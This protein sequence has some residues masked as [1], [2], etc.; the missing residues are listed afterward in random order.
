MQKSKTNQKLGNLHH[1]FSQMRL[2]ICPKTRLL[3]LNFANN[4]SARPKNFIPIMLMK[5][6]NDKHFEKV[7]KNQFKNLVSVL[8]LQ[9]QLAQEVHTSFSEK[10]YEDANEQ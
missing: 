4:T 5:H 10:N 3:L 1:I 8:Q 9:I 2:Q 6:Q 7:Q